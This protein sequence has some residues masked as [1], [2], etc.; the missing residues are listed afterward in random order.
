MLD[1]EIPCRRLEPWQYRHDVT[2]NVNVNCHVAP[3]MAFDHAL[4]A[5]RVPVARLSCGSA[6]T[7]RDDK[8]QA[9][10]TRRLP[11]N[12]G[13]SGSSWIPFRRQSLDLLR[14][15][16]LHSSCTAGGSHQRERFAP[17]GARHNEDVVAGCHVGVRDGVQD[18][19]IGPSGR[20]W[21]RRAVPVWC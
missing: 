19:S 14:Q 12:H 11:G 10:T 13:T 8:A 5:G 18:R 16:L 21:Q 1:H 4:L 17:G 15:Q 9:G 7:G 20:T 6:A 3:A 2:V